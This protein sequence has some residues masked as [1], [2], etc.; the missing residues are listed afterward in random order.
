MEAKSHC[1]PGAA[2]PQP[3]MVEADASNVCP[4]SAKWVNVTF[5]NGAKVNK[6]DAELESR[7]RG[8][9]EMHLVESQAADEF[10]EVR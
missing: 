10:T 8:P 6:I 7:P 3:I 5:A 4:I 2:S 1:S 9:H